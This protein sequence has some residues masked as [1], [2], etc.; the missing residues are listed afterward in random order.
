MS[1]SKKTKSTTAKSPAP[2]T[3]TAP[4]KSAA[5]TKAVVPAKAPAPAKTTKA[6]APATPAPRPAPVAVKPVARK[7]VLT[8][9]S[10]RVDVGFGN[11]LYIRGEGAGLSWD[12]GLLM[13]CLEADLWRI[14]LPESA[15]GHIFKFLVNDLSWSAGPDYTVPGGADVTLTPEF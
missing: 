6:A 3:K 15:H 8:T 2:A 9:I 4:A 11:A 12:Q 14:T 10:A 1:A 5:K 13:E 7:P